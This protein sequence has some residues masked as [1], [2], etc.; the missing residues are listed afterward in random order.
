M[1]IQF[2]SWEETVRWPKNSTTSESQNDL[3]S[4]ARELD[5]RDS[6]RTDSSSN[7]RETLFGLL[8]SYSSYGPFSNTRWEKENPGQFAGKYGSLE[9]IHDTIHEK[10]GGRGPPGHMARVPYA[11]FDPAFWLHHA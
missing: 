10:V 3:I 4:K 9:S 7:L 1:S 5:N 6:S 2:N 8:V 11:A